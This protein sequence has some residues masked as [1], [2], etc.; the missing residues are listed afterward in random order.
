MRRTILAGAKGRSA[1]LLALLL[2][3]G[4]LAGCGT[5]TINFERDVTAYVAGLD[6]SQLRDF[7]VYHQNTIWNG[8][9]PSAVLLDI[10]DGVAFEGAGWS[11][12]QDEEAPRLLSRAFERG[13]MAT[14]LRDTGGGLL[15]YLVATEGWYGE[16]RNRYRLIVADDGESYDVAHSQLFRGGNGRDD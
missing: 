7:D 1:P 8:P 4:A 6:G 2:L 13:L 15:G 12:A 9:R 11:G 10:R 5:H 3:A 16:R 14:E